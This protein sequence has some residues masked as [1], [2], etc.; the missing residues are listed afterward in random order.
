MIVC[1]SIKRVADRYKHFAIVRFDKI[2]YLPFNITEYDLVSRADPFSAQI[3]VQ[4]ERPRT[5]ITQNEIWKQ[6]G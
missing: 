6:K 3:H 1:R 5:S 4:M 2:Q